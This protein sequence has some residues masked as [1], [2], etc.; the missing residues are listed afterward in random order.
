MAQGPACALAAPAAAVVRHYYIPVHD[1]EGE[2]EGEVGQSS[3]RQLNLIARL[4]QAVQ[5]TDGEQWRRRGG[6]EAEAEAELV[7]VRNGYSS[8][9]E[10]RL[11]E[12]NRRWRETSL[13]LQHEAKAQ[14]CVGMHAGVEVPW[15]APRFVLL[16]LDERQ[17]VTQVYC[18]ALAVGYSEGCAE[19]WATLA[20]IVLDACYEAV[21]LCAALEQAE[22]RGSG[23]VVLTFL[24]G[25]VFGNKAEW[26]ESA[27]ARAVV[28][29]TNVGLRVELCHFGEVDERAVTRIEHAIAAE[30]SK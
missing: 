21:L 12:L 2:G 27:L 8:S 16:P 30:R 4:L 26:I 28:R 3:Q 1:G 7:R 24:G 29:L 13:A 25:G 19:S 18:S 17:T 20:C 9:D 5:G 14:M 22:G 23:R 11:G 6:G 15:G 10:A